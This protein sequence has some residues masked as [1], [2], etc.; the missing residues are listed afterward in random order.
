MTELFKA[1]SILGPI[2]ITLT[3]ML[4]DIVRFLFIY[5]VI[6]TGFVVAI[7]KVYSS[8]ENNRRIVEGDYKEQGE[9]Y[10]G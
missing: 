4:T 3:K 7:T 6:I 9:G 5:L 8:Y 1:S 2:Q 10:I